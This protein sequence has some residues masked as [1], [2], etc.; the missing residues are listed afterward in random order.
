MQRC[1]GP[2][3]GLQS[4]EA[5]S[6]QI[7]QIKN[8][9]RGHIKPLLQSLKEQMLEAAAHQDFK[10]AQQYKEKWQLLEQYQSKSAVVSDK[11][12]DVDVLQVKEKD[13]FIYFNYMRIVDGLMVQAH[14]I[15]LRKKLDETPQD[16]WQ[17]VLVDFRQRYASTAQEVILP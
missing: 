10:T 12:S 16:L 5:Y 1:E 17:S 8:L 9:L 11:L 14:T 7:D 15:D 2:C 3:K 6:E 13:D 4:H